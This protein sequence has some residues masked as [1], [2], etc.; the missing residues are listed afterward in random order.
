MG[1]EH[2]ILS[3]EL[4][5]PKARD[6]GGGLITYGRIPLMI[7]ERCFIRESFGCKNCGKASL[8]DRKGEKFPMKRESDHRNLI[9]NSLPTY[10][11]DKQQELFEMKLRSHHLLFTVE[12]GSEILEILRNHKLGRPLAKPV[13]RVGRR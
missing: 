12:E 4:T 11:G 5:L 2:L 8:T 10:M 6:I 13:R 7:T 9:F 3:P 1:V